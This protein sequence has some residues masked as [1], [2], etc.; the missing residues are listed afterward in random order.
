ML[1]ETTLRSWCRGCLVV[2]ALSG[3]LPAAAAWTSAELPG[4]DIR[5]L[6]VDP[7]DADFVMAGTASGQVFVS[8]DG[9]TTWKA[10]GDEL[11]FRGWV[12]SDL[13]IDSERPGRVW[14]A[15]RS[16]HSEDGF[17]AVSEDRGATWADRS[18]GLPNRQVYA[19]EWAPGV[20]YAATRQG[21]F[22]SRDEGSQWHHLTAEH[23]EIQKV[24]SLLVDAANPLRV[25]AGTWRR[26]Y[27]SDDGG[28]TWRGVF[29]GMVLDSEVFTLQASPDR[30]GEL[31]ASTCGWV[32]RSDDLGGRWVRLRNGLT[33]RRTPSF[34]ALPDGTRLAGTVRGVYRS[35]SN[36]EAWELVTPKDLVAL[37]MAH[38]PARPERIFVG[39]EG[40]G[41]WRSDD[42][43]RSFRSSSRGMHAARI[44]ALAAAGDEV[45]AA[46]RHAGPASGLY[47]S[48]DGG[49]TY[50][51]GPVRLPTVNDL[52]SDGSAMLAATNGGLFERREGS[53]QRVASVGRSAV[54]ELAVDGQRAV[55]RTSDGLFLRSDRDQEFA[56]I[57]FD[58]GRPTSVAAEAGILWV[59]SSEGLYRLE[60]GQ[61]VASSSPLRSARIDLVAGSLMMAGAGEL[62]IRRGVGA[63]WEELGRGTRF[64]ATGDRELPLLLIDA[65]GDVRLLAH[66]GRTARRLSMSHPPEDVSAALL[67]DRRLILGTVGH[68][69][70]VGELDRLEGAA[71][72][73]V[74]TGSR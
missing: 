20:L 27:R 67:R 52:A 71:E 66:D 45:I 16:L 40:A 74:V 38:H 37:V 25:L 56:R 24:G 35:A 19:L 70:L 31:W 49:R 7:E 12:V 41:V 64:L 57:P 8:V 2:T 34:Q 73:S 10:A 30:S 46:V 5:A 9:G 3:G 21:V 22:G 68:G 32:Y 28:V 62:W 26:A 55:A 43:G 4:G 33:E 60:G 51:M 47:S 1:K 39:S 72:P 42:G 63:S 14:A 53:W 48:F 54:H 13:L 61:P 11:P 23:P 69:L 59:S 44:A 18:A 17:V 36:G 29:D 15:L 65:D 6:A 50:S 58:R